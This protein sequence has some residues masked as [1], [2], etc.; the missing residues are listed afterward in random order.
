MPANIFNFISNNVKGLKS[1]KKQIKLFEYFKSKLAP[2]SVL[3]AQETHSTKEIEQKWKDELN[4]QIFFSHGKS[5]SCGIFIAFL[6]SKSVTIT[7][8]VS[9]NSGRIL[10]LQVKIEDEIYLLVNLY[11]SNN[12]PE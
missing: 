4:G 5:N 12:E 8:E 1:T 6:G 7:K 2:S 11:N 9:D 3:F 10:V